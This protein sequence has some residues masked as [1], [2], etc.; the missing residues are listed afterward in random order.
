V[1]KSSARRAAQLLKLRRYKTRAIYAL[2]RRDPASRVHFWSWFLQSVIEGEIDLNHCDFSFWGSLK[3]NVYNS[4]PQMEELKIFIR[5][6]KISLQNSPEV[7]HTMTEH[8]AD[9]SNKF[10]C[11]NN[12][13][14]CET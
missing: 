11:M 13:A 14:R 12:I 8:T 7:H 9:K 10:P 1:L 4:N 6:L 5:K 3:G 2:Q